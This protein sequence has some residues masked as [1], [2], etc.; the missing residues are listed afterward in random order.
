[1]AEKRF[2]S[3]IDPGILLVIIAM[4]IMDFVLI[5]ALAMESGS[6]AGRTGA[7]LVCIALM[8]LLSS[9]ALR[10]YYAVDKNVLR[11]VSGPFRWKIPIDQITSVTPT[12][13]VLS[14]PAM[15]LDRLKIEYGKLRPMIVS[16]ADKKGFLRAL[17]HNES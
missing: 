1:M 16:P 2:K 12:R 8:A 3:K 7:I 15:S 11:V 4:V 10:T 9:L 5:V 14:S 6:P 17:D 13:T